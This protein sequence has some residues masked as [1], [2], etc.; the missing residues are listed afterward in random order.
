M[1]LEPS[2]TQ[3][4]DSRWVK[5]AYGV[6]IGIA[7]GLSFGLHSSTAHAELKTKGKGKNIEFVRDQFEEPFLTQYDVFQSKCT[8]CHG[9][10]RPIAAITTGIT[11]VSGQVFNRKFVKS[12]VIKMMRKPNSGIK[13]KEVKPIVLFILQA[14]ERNDDPR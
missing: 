5:C 8:K 4:S 3:E 12:Y 11:P 7:C 9:M 2:I 13:R 14:L 6:V 10:I 1:N